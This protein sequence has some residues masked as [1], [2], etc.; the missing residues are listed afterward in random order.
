M[1]G[2]ILKIPFFGSRTAQAKK[3][4]LLTDSLLHHTYRTDI[5]VLLVTIT[6]LQHWIQLS[7]NNISAAF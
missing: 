5:Q 1:P 6:D 2:A 7:I 3:K 4:F